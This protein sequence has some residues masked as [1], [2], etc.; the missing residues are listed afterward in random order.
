MHILDQLGVALGLATLAGVN[1]YLT[2]FLT[3]LAVRFDWL[4]LAQQHQAREHR[5]HQRCVRPDGEGRCPDC[6]G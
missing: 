3:G 2:V 1:L 4:Q 5:R 6:R